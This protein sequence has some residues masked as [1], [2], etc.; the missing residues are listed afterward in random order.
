MKNNRILSI[1]LWVIAVVLF[2]IFGFGRGW[3]LSGVGVLAVFAIGGYF[4]YSR[5]K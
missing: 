1:A 2:L 5:G 4:F 3:W